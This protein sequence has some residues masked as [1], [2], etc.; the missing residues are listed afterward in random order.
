MT[1]NNLGSI[2]GYATIDYLMIEA[3]NIL[4]V[5]F[6]TKQFDKYLHY[7]NWL[8]NIYKTYNLEGKRCPVN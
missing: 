4:P 1:Y 7:S 2:T 8:Q 6:K 3:E 5:L